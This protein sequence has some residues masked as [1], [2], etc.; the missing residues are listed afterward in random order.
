MSATRLQSYG[1]RFFAHRQ[2]CWWRG[3]SNQCH[4]FQILIARSCTIQKTG[5]RGDA[6][7]HDD[8][9][10]AQR[11]YGDVV[12]QWEVAGDGAASDLVTYI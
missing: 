9:G 8:L 5:K 4:G 10:R 6:D 7:R 3:G 2:G 12:I 1:R 11:A